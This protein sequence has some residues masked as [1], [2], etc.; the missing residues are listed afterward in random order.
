[1]LIFAADYVAERGG[2]RYNLGLEGQERNL[3]TFA[4]GKLNML[5]HGL[6]S[7][8]LVP[9]DVIAEPGL[10]DQ[11]G[12]L[13]S[14][15]RVIANPL[16]SMKNWGHEFAPSDPHHRFDCYGAILPRTR[17]DLTFLLHML[18]V[19][20]AEGMVGV[21]MPHGVLFRGGGEDKIRKGIVDADLFEAIIG[22]APN[23]FFDPSIPVSICEL[24]KA[25]PAG[26]RGKVLFVDTAQDCCYRP[27]KAQN[28][29]DQEHI[30][31]I[32]SAFQ[33][34]EDIE[35]FAH[36]PDLEEIAGNDYNLNI[37]RY[38]DTTEPVD[39]MSV[40][41]ALAQLR[42]AERRRDEAVARMDELLAGMGYTR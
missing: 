32:V 38:V 42:E 33:A 39:V 13:Q 31:H 19:T 22:L 14:Y 2:D 17:G 36:V 9:G 27:G 37:S 5:L 28:F 23:L 3:G 20:N 16:F 34:Y 26:R 30:D 29:L 12:R 40:E 6:A 25:K 11:Q 24:N 41:D 7:A 18:G 8:R 35:R 1:M 15:D 21:V 10:V 4:I